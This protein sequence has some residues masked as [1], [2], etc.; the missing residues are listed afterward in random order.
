MINNQV[1]ITQNEKN[2]KFESVQCQPKCT[3]SD[4]CFIKGKNEEMLMRGHFKRSSKYIHN[5]SRSP[6]NDRNIYFTVT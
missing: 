2:Q 5:Y 6:S 4:F 1:S 3:H